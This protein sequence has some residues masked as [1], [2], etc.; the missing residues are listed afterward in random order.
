MTASSSSPTLLAK[1]VSTT[2]G[3]THIDLN[4][5]AT[6]AK[7]RGSIF[8]TD[9]A[10]QTVID[11]ATGEPKLRVVGATFT[12]EIPLSQVTV[13]GSHVSFDAAGLA[14]GKHYSIFMG[15]GTLTSGGSPFAGYTV[16]NQVAF[17]V[18]AAPSGLSASFAFENTSLKAG[19]DI[20][21]Y[22]TLSQSVAS[23]DAS[24]FSAENAS[25]LSVTG[26]DDPRIWKVVLTRST[27]VADAENVLRLDLTKVETAPGVHGSGTA[28][29]PSY[30]VDTLVNPWISLAG[31]AWDSGVSR[32][33][34]LINSTTPYLQGE[35]HGGLD[36]G[37]V[38]ELFINGTRVDSAHIDVVRESS[39]W[40]WSYSPGDGEEGPYFDE[41]ANTV[42][43][44]VKN[45]DHTSAAYSTTVTVDTVAPEIDAR[46]SETAALPLTEDIVITFTET[47]YWANMESDMMSVSV[48]CPEDGTVRDVWIDASAFIGGGD[49][50]TL[51]PSELELETGKHYELRLPDGLTDYAGNSLADPLIGFHTGAVD[52]TGPS[53]THV[54]VAGER[55]DDRFFFKA[56]DTI[57][58][59][60]K[61]DEAIRQASDA[62]LSVELSN[63][64]RAEVDTIEGDEVTFTY[65]VEGEDTD[66]GNLTITDASMLIENIE[67]LAG[68]PLTGA[69]IV[70]D[71][72]HEYMGFGYGY[73]PVGVTV[74]T[75][76]PDAPA[77]PSLAAGSDS[78]IAD[79][80][81]TND[82]TPTL[83]G[84]AEARAWVSIYEGSTCLGGI[85][86]DESGKWEIGIDSELGAGT[87]N[88]RIVQ[89]DRAG[90]ESSDTSYALTI[91][92]S[93]DALEAPV[94][95][96]GTTL[97]GSGAEAHADIKIISGETVVGVGSADADGN[98]T[99]LFGAPLE[100]GSHTYTV[101]QIDQAGNVSGDSAP[102]TFTVDHSAPPVSM[103]TPDLDAASDSGLSDHDDITNTDTPTFTG[104][105][106][107]PGRVVVL[108][109]NG[110]EKGRIEADASGN[111]RITSS[112]LADG[113]YSIA[114]RELDADGHAVGSSESL[115]VRIDTMAPELLSALANQSR[116]EFELSF[117]EDVDFTPAGFFQ[118]KQNDANVGHFDADSF[119]WALGGGA[120]GAASVLSL[121]VAASG[122]FKLEMNS[123]AIADLAG[124]VAVFV[125]TPEWTFDL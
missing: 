119:N 26:T 17:D 109:A 108:Y 88:L 90:N 42:T 75:E 22:V 98:W 69:H 82:R 104:G 121:D 111:W 19:Q 36:D 66:I 59:R 116:K 57:T 120:G 1:T 2:A 23:L 32:E 114:I 38:I 27:S 72:L 73:L 51:D 115:G 10:V 101:R 37:D 44:H 86:A 125:G 20:E 118:L 47:L 45:G 124:N 54:L 43:V 25:V 79:D 71:G 96:G 8:V 87:H 31:P 52:L 100:Q 29:S 123:S 21:V 81:I 74:D 94:L 77:T 12:K 14:G 106:A 102:I 84:I 76:A 4:F 68:N 9:G 91:D 6:M 62:I 33:D 117:D 16:P 49:V 85:R 64:G 105:G 53:A 56:N 99:A 92:Y 113:D 89:T 39:P 46:P 40:T 70:F 35:L 61:F 58:F 24:A 48:Y 3:V 30:A 95:T 80:D 63:G 41:G 67:D 5:S 60:V 13:N 11:R 55:I 28:T 110:V 83:K 78:G 93:A 15:A 97:T 107:V 112:R 34:N 65:T 103:D 7:G 50:L 18:A 122:R